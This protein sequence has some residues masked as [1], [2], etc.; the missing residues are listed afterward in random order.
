[1]CVAG[2]KKAAIRNRRCE[3]TNGQHR[4]SCGSADKALD[5]QG[6]LEYVCCGRD[7]P[8]RWIPQPFF[9]YPT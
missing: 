8:L 4:A 2:Y 5:W 3:S 1:M 7:G 9:Q 6:E